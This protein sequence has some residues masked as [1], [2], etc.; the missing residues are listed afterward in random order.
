VRLVAL[1]VVSALAPMAAAQSLPPDAYPKA[2]ASY[3]VAVDGRVIWQRAADVSRAPASLTKIMTALVLIDH[4]FDPEAVVSISRRAAAIGGARLGLRSGQKMTA[5]ALFTAMLVRSANDAC[6]ALAEHAAGSVEVFVARMNERAARL[7]L[8]ATHFANPCGLDARRHKSSARDLL[9]L[10]EVALTRPLFTKT[11]SLQ[12]ARVR[13]LGGPVFSLESSNALL[14]RVHGA[15]G[16]KTGFTGA[17]G[18][19]VIAAADRG[20]TRVI[21]VLLDSP[22]RWWAAAALIER[23]FERAGAPQ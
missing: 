23:A 5:G 2:A 1:L 18:N 9:H 14:G 7:D 13:V 16:V 3:L 12:R 10:T 17:A 15:I 19:S 21:A 6:T 8:S 22:D 20:R 4:G 11:V